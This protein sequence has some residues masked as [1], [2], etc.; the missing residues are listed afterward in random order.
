[1]LTQL[2]PYQIQEEI[3]KGGMGTVYRAYH[4]ALDRHVAIKVLPARLSGDNNFLERFKREAQIIARLEHPHILP[5]YDF[6]YDREIAYLVMKLVKGSSLTSRIGNKGM[7]PAEAMSILHAVGDALSHAHLRNIIHRDIKPDNILIDDNGSVYLS[8]FGMAKMVTGT[9]S[10]GGFIMGTPEYMAPEQA[11]GSKGVDSRADVYSLSIVVFQM[12][13]G[14][15]PFRGENPIATIKKL[16]DEPLPDITTRN[17]LLPKMVDLLLQKGAAKNPAERFSDVLEMVST[18]EAVFTGTNEVITSE[19]TASKQKI[20]VVPF[21]C[22]LPEKSWM[23]VAMQE[24]LVMD[25]SQT[26][27]LFLFSPDHVT[28]MCRNILEPNSQWTAGPLQRL[29]E[30]S[31]ADY[32]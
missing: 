11:K 7:A 10:T 28:R 32:V 13:S 21:I 14:S 2:G 27:G 9:D 15:I 29:F 16:L 22:R 26:A 6:A 8:D 30:L 25:L 18:M 20:V 12:L 4:P 1:M 24:M 3:G 17:P 5:V 31:R 23:S 19:V